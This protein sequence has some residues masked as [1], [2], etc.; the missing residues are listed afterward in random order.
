MLRSPVGVW[1][2][3]PKVKDAG[4]PLLQKRHQRHSPLLSHGSLYPLVPWGDVVL[5]EPEGQW[6]RGS[7]SPDGRPEQS[8]ILPLPTF[9]HQ[10]L[11]LSKMEVAF[12]RRPS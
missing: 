6:Y 4:D 11:Q 10:H 8:C 9:P 2:W 12:L 7:L 1:G 3:P 5:L